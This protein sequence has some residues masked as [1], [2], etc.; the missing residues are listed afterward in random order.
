MKARADTTF[1]LIVDT[2]SAHFSL[3]IA[4]NLP[5]PETTATFV[6]FLQATSSDSFG[7][8]FEDL[9]EH[10]R[11]AI[12]AFKWG[13]GFLGR[14]RETLKAV[15][16][17][18]GN[19]GEVSFAD[20]LD[21]FA[22]TRSLNIGSIEECNLVCTFLGES[23]C[24]QAQQH[25]KAVVDDDAVQALRLSVNQDFAEQYGTWQT[26]MREPSDGQEDPMTKLEDMIKASDVLGDSRAKGQL[27]FCALLAKGSSRNQAVA[28]KWAAAETMDAKCLSP[29][30]VKVVSPARKHLKRMQSM[31]DQHVAKPEEASSPFVPMNPE[32]PGYDPLHLWFLDNGLQY[33]ESLRG[34]IGCMRKSL[35]ECYDTWTSILKTLCSTLESFCP[36]W[37]EWLATGTFPTKEH[38]EKLTGNKN[39]PQLA[40]VTNSLDTFLTSMR[41]LVDQDGCG[42]FVD[43][44]QAIGHT[45]FFTSRSA[46]TFRGLGFVATWFHSSCFKHNVMR[47]CGQSCAPV[48]FR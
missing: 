12:A 35:Q 22:K 3:L 14:T 21:L 17:M 42:P 27:S 44:Q 37:N 40:P 45:G 20:K 46:R 43:A 15:Q 31:L 25:L 33:E 11:P 36:P 5:A 24:E 2:V 38:V 39:Y 26:A 9:I 29:E 32:S 19:L 13:L 4:E 8:L 10:T 41:T 23:S 34:A 47:R 28:G 1:H 16:A 48:P 18:Q 6:L 30:W 7:S